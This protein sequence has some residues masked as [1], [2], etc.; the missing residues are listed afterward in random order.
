[1]GICVDA[2]GVQKRAE[3]GAVHSVLSAKSQTI[4][5]KSSKYF[6]PLSHSSNTKEIFLSFWVLH[7]H[8]GEELVQRKEE[9]IA[10]DHGSSSLS[11]A[12][13]LPM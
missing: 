10:A 1:M 11:S 8:R 7:F 5:W 3:N 9:N 6:S 13:V 4:L 12:V 2:H